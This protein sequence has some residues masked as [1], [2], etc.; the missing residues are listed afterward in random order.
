MLIRAAY[1]LMFIHRVVLG[2]VLDT[3]RPSVLIRAAY[4]LMFIHR[5]VLAVVLD[6]DRPAVSR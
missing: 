6:T 4:I 2:V 1:I 3:D 5:V